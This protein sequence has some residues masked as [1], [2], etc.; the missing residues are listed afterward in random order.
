MFPTNDDLTLAS[1]QLPRSAFDTVRRD[2]VIHYEKALRSRAPLADQ[3]RGAEI[4]EPVRGIADLPTFFRTS[5]GPGWVLAGDA[6]HHKDPV[7]APPGVA[8]WLARNG[9]IRARARS[10]PPG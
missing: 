3:L 5:A 1:V 6:G 9:R 10:A 2:P 7:I 8:R 4:V